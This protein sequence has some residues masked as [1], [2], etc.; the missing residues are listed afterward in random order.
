MPSINFNLKNL[1][2]FLGPLLFIFLLIWVVDPNQALQYLRGIR[3]SMVLI[4]FLL[5]PIVM[6]LKTLRW[7][8][9]CQHLDL[10]ISMGRLFQINY[11]SWFLGNFP[12]GGIAAISK[13]V[14]FKEEGKP[15]GSTFVSLALE[16]I[17]DI[18]GLLLFG[19][20]G[21]FYF[22]RDMIDEKKLWIILSLIGLM[23]IVCLILKG[24]IAEFSKRWFKKRLLKQLKQSSDGFGEALEKFWSGFQF[25]LVVG[26]MVLSISIYL[27]MSLALYFLAL[28]LGIGLSFGFTAAC[29]AL[30]G[31]AN[32]IPVTV[33]GLG[34]RDA[35]LL[36]TLPLAGYSR[37]AALALGFTAFL[38][39]TLFKFSGVVYWLKNPLPTKAILSFKKKIFKGK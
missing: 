4:S 38:W 35:I 10:T 11:I 7:W 9:V 17:L 36:F 37:E 39:A 18:F 34:T 23:V 25:K 19:L 29:T 5:F 33:S 21:L 2:K 12:F 1:I 13:I 8:I 20:Y 32:I 22:P 31:I 28:A 24:R 6:Y 16:K 15:I 30:I 27:L 26:I 14:Y 3:I